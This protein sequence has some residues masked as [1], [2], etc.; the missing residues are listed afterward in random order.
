MQQTITS[1]VAIPQSGKPPFTQGRLS[2]FVRFAARCNP[3][4]GETSIHTSAS[5]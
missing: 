5:V 3:A 1:Q 2:R 4:I